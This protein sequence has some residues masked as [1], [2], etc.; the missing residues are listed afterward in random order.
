MTRFLPFFVRRWLHRLLEL[1]PLVRKPAECLEVRQQLEP[2]A[3]D[4]Y[5]WCS[6]GADPQFGWRYDLPAPGW[7]ML[8]VVLRHDQPLAGLRVYFNTGD[9]FSDAGSFYLPLKAGR[10]TKRLCRVPNRVKSIRIDPMES[11]GQFTFEHLRFA[12]V[13]T[14]MALDRLARRLV[15]MHYH[16]QE[17]RFEDVLPG[18]R[19]EASAAGT[20]WLALAAKYYEETFARMSMAWSYPEWLARN[21]ALTATDIGQRPAPVG[22]RFEVLLAVDSPDRSMV[23]RSV[24]AVEHQVWGD[25]CLK[26]V[27]SAALSESE[28]AW[29]EGIV[30]ADDR[31]SLELC[32]RPL[33]EQVEQ[34]VWRSEADWLVVMEPGDALSPDAFWWVATQAGKQPEL[35]LLYCD[36]DCLD[37]NG[38]RFGPSFRPD[39]NPDLLLS[40]NYT[41]KA[42]WLKPEAIRRGVHRFGAGLHGWRYGV[43]LQLGIGAGLSVHHVPRVL[44]H[45]RR[46][47]TH[48]LEAAEA[49]STLAHEQWSRAEAGRQGVEVI[50]VLG[51]VRQKYPVPSKPPLVSLLIPTR[52]GVEILE[53][54]VDAILQRSTYPNFEVLILDNQ[55]DC[56]R[57]LEYMGNVTERD[58]RVRVLRWDFPFNYSAINNFGVTEARGEVIGLINNDIE[59]I[60]GDW[61]DEMVGHVLRPEVGCVGAKLYYPNETIQHGGVILGIG[62]VAGHSHKYLQR[63]AE[64]YEYRLKLVQNLSAV[65]GA[66]LLVR[67]SVFEEVGGL[68]EANL[69]V[70]FNDVD[71]CL[72]VREAGYRNV[73]TPFAEAY[74]H[75]SVSRGADD[76][77]EKRDRANREA[78]YMKQRWGQVLMHDPAYN[79]NLT[80]IHEDFSLR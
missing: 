65:T 40:R 7:Y 2:S 10:L 37:E 24:A 63:D 66:C 73:W 49:D 22:Y 29:F 1:T 8:E 16:W 76:T 28:C 21:P 31:L 30:A 57:T 69:A 23:S 14:R 18:I 43:M 53:P 47:D 3:N 50:K 78:A 15:N 26:M 9:G 19:K 74:H 32:S 34:E 75:E 54:C 11:A 59:P 36:E 25:W 62:G 70:A 64:G 48:E 27:V 60:N 77:P 39:W 68:E 79:P 71:F 51:G 55:S 58:S 44:F 61:L 4:D 45:G 46:A 52:N 56:A 5:D 67:K 72:K 20:D 13:T 33:T 42:L 80:L 35:P 38:G 6:T 41:G 17:T 12:R